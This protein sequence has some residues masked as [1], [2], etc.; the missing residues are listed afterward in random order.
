MAEEPAER[1]TFGKQAV[2]EDEAALARQLRHEHM[3]RQPWCVPMWLH[4][5]IGAS[6]IH[7]LLPEDSRQIWN[8]YITLRDRLSCMYPEDSIRAL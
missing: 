8:T 3:A 2:K 7:A 5:D 6:R 1:G 4:S